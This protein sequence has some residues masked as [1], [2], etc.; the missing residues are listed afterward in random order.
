MHVVAVSG[1]AVAASD[2]S[3]KSDV[4]D[5]VVC[6]SAILFVL[7]VL[8]LRN[9]RWCIAMLTSVRSRCLLAL[10]TPSTA[11]M[12]SGTRTTLSEATPRQDLIR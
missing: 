1:D 2:V 12:M 4:S 9:A 6:V 11:P 5:V 8:C 7:G 3:E 10:S